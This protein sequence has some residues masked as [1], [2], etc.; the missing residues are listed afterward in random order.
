MHFLTDFADQAVILPLMLAVALA[1]ALGG[2]RRGAVAWLFGIAATLAAVLLGKVFVCACD[3]LPM[4]DLRSP[5]GH[6]AAAAVAYGGLLALLAPS[7]RRAPLLA[8]AGAVAAA[9][10]IGGSRLALGM[11]TASD[12]L[13][14][15]V[16]GVAGA[17]V[18]A[19]LAGAR[20]P[21]LPRALPVAAALAVVIVFHGVHLHAEDRINEAC[22][23]F[24]R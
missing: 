23:T 21:R 16:A 20:P 1:L 3:P 9:V 2:W 8:A 6:T 4:L 18:L 12:V 15:A 19:R 17:L 13:V 22:H 14:G 24:W 7:G 11:H 10:L 5:S